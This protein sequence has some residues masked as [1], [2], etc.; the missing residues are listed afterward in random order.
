MP[1]FLVNR[2][3]VSPTW[4]ASGTQKRSLWLP[5]P[6]QLINNNTSK[7]SYPVS[8][9]EYISGICSFHIWLWFRL[10]GT[11]GA[12]FWPSQIFVCSLG[13]SLWWHSRLAGPMGAVGNSPVS[14]QALFPLDP[15]H[16]GSCPSW[17]ELWI[18]VFHIASV[19]S[20]GPQLL[21]LT[22]ARPAGEF[23]GWA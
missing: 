2:T 17:W 19:P 11:F 9:R 8:N 5:Q 15:V 23:H 1:G 4:A 7:L 13:S 18:S 10:S 22:L 21:N 14:T 16:L 12:F 6:R 3:P 20:C